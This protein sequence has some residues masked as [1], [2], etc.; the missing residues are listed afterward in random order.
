MGE[1][2]D[3]QHFHES[4][5]DLQGIGRDPTQQEHLIDHEKEPRDGPENQDFP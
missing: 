3:G 4:K 2:G 5:A 1:Y